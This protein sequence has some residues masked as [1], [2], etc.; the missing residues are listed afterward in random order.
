MNTNDC[1][2]CQKSFATNPSLQVHMKIKHLNK[3]PSTHLLYESEK[4]LKKTNS[5]KYHM[6]NMS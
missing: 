4:S 6:F 2:N 3:Q 5:T 1:S